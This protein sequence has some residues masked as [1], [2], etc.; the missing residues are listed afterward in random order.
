MNIDEVRLN[1]N[2]DSILLINLLIGFIMYSVSLDLRW[3]DFVNLFRNPKPALIGL[4]SQ[5]LLLPL[6]TSLIILIWKPHPSLALGMILVAACPGGNMSNFFTL[7]AKGNLAL[8]VSLTAITSTLAFVMTPISFL[9]FGSINPITKDFLKE[10]ALNPSDLFTSVAM[11]LLLPLALGLC[12]SHYF[13]NLIQRVKSWLQRISLLFLAFFIVG[14]LLANFRYF[15]DYI[16]ILFGLV[17]FMNAAGLFVGYY[18]SSLFSLPVKDRRTISIE[19]GIQNSSLGL[20]LVFLFFDGQGGMALISAWWGIWHLI[21]GATISYIWSKK[22]A[23][24]NS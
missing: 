19:T 5:Y 16:L 11:L 7:L 14:A 22:S 18:W 9:F 2:K 23:E 12:S 10:I 24:A 8:S 3:K 15:I 4:I 13:P 6:T 20:A 1:F 17:F 21:S